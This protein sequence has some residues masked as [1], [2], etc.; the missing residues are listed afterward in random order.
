MLS[1][2]GSNYYLKDGCHYRHR[3]VYIGNKEDS[4]SV[5]KHLWADNYGLK[6][7]QISLFAIG[8]GYLQF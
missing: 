2:T 4:S 6:S 8:Y 1:V 7:L 5:D 3:P